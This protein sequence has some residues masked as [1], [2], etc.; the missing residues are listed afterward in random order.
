[1]NRLSKQ[2]RAAVVAALVEGMSIRATVRMTGV[3]KNTVAKLLVDLGNA[4]ERYHDAN[5]RGLRSEQ[6]QADEIWAFCYAKEKNVPDDLRGEFGYGDV[7]TWTA[8]DADSKLMVSWLVGRRDAAHAE[9]FIRDVASRVES[10]PQITTDG[11]Q[12]YRWAVAAAFGGQVDYAQ[13]QKIYGPVSAPEGRYSRPSARAARRRRSWATPT[14]RR[15][16]RATSSART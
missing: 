13:V 4:C 11:L 6:I 10:R 8:I 14:W 16:R 3:A 15:S 9:M 7:W 12:V 2:K 5:V 1:M